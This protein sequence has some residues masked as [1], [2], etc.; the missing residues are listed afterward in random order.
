MQK[1]RRIF[2]LVSALPL[3]LTSCEIWHG[4]GSKNRKIDYMFECLFRLEK[5]DK[6]YFLKVSNITKYQ[7]D[8]A[9]GINVINDFLYT[10]TE[11]KYYSVHFYSSS[12]DD[13]YNETI[14]SYDFVCL[15]ESN[16]DIKNEPICYID[17]HKNTI[18][19]KSASR[20]SLHAY[21]VTYN[22]MSF[23]FSQEV[24]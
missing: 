20:E 7:Y 6:F 4:W 19:P 14:E 21:W 11:P 10:K 17:S 13:P 23:S 18:S 1:N 24:E 5:N 2:V 8:I 3:I 12:I 15:E 22:E 16:P 9:N